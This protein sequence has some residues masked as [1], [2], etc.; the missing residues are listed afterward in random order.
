MIY[1]KRTALELLNGADYWFVEEIH[2]ILNDFNAPLTANQKTDLA[3]LFRQW[4]IERGANCG[5]NLWYEVMSRFLVCV[6][7]GFDEYRDNHGRGRETAFESV[8]QMFSSIVT[9]LQIYDRDSRCLRFGI[10]EM[11]DC[12]FSPEDE[13]DIRSLELFE[14]T[15][16]LVL[17]SALKMIAYHLD[18][19][20]QI[21]AGAVVG[22]SL[23]PSV[24]DIGDSSLEGFFYFL[25][26]HSSQSHLSLRK[27][28]FTPHI[29]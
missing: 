9:R 6:R 21:P 16:Y 19:L 4:R 29:D 12:G 1:L 20:K 3:N 18:S 26:V 28:I 13:A 5:S 25:P 15:D 10:D 24:Q 2:L 14:M 22:L 7:E 23:C 27:P 11:I 8:R 17:S